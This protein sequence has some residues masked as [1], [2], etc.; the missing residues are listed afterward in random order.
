[1]QPETQ[2]EEKASEER[3]LFNMKAF[4]IVFHSFCGLWALSLIILTLSGGFDYIR[5][6]LDQRVSFGIRHALGVMKP[7]DPRIKIFVIDDAT[8]AWNNSSPDF[9][10]KDWAL[11]LENF[12]KSEPKVILIDKIF[13]ANALA[14]E[15]KKE[16]VT[17]ALKTISNL[18]TPVYIGVFP[19][20]TPLKYRD[21]VFLDH[22]YDLS[23]YLKPDAPLNPTPSKAAPFVPHHFKYVYG[24]N[25]VFRGVFKG[26]SHI[27]YDNK[28]VPSIYPVIA[29]DGKHFMPHLA[30]RAADSL[31]FEDGALE[32]NG[33]KVPTDKNGL[34]QI[35][36]RHPSA[37]R[38][39][40]LKGPMKRARK[41][42]PE[43][44]ISKG[45]VVFIV[46]AFYTG[47]ADMHEGGPFGEIPGGYIIAEIIDSLLTE[48]WLSVFE[49]E[50]ALI[51]L[52]SL[53]GAFVG[54]KSHPLSF[55]FTLFGILAGL[56]ILFN[57]LFVY[58]DIVVPWSI[59]LAAF[60]GV[61][62]GQYA[63]KILAGEVKR[64]ELQQN[65][66]KEKVKRQKE[67][68]EKKILQEHLK[69]GK[70]VQEMLLPKKTAGF[71]GNIDYKM[72]YE[73]AQQM[74]GDWLYYWDYSEKEKRIFIGDVVG[75]GPPAALPVAVIISTFREAQEANL[76]C[77]ETIKLI[78]NRVL[79]HFA[80]KVTS[81]LA[82]VS[83][84]E[85]RK[86]EFYNAGSPG[87]FLVQKDGISFINLRSSPLGLKENNLGACDSK[88]LDSKAMFF[89][90]TDGYMEG[91]RAAK[92]LM[93]F[94]KKQD[95]DALSHDKIHNGLLKTG[96]GHRLEDDMTMV[97][98]KMG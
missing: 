27:V 21:K 51:L 6:R 66:L 9:A 70:T 32:I 62:L 88:T 1:M 84:F 74:S 30:L 56:F 94:I 48:R 3:P 11:L 37:F 28:A 78:N 17:R 89:T 52:L 42:I 98:V 67:E 86:V 58:H 4:S 95:F 10:M 68:G 31:Y 18:K 20:K 8:L 35:N 55:W 40:M 57:Y 61:A 5:S 45:D 60:F 83:L 24:P 34:V 93:H 2:Q 97:S 12:S 76:S 46:P 63:V 54:A 96:Q 65:F 19:R 92:R 29:V 80:T 38:P 7:V 47:N 59:P 72:R 82:G 81:T 79:F 87:W 77:Q 39:I 22:T 91:A 69:L 44:F 14:D 16:E 43:K 25:K 75:K 33:K 71:F 53:L 64:G 36:H 13:G 49:Y 26:V 50:I 73:P 23:N 90:F 41:K 15:S 85:D